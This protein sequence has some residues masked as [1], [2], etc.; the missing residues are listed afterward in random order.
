MLQAIAGYDAK[1]ANSVEMPVGDL[2]A[3]QDGSTRVKIGVPRKFFYADLD[4]EVASAVEDA[5][6][7][8]RS[9]GNDLLEIEIYVPTDRIL[10][11]AE[12][13]AYHREFI[14][15]SPELYQP[16]TLRRIRTGEDIS[17]AQVEQAERELKQTR[18]EIGKVFERVDFLVTPTAPIPAPAISDLKSDPNALRPC[19]LVLLRN[20]RPANVW[21]LP[22]ISIPCG[23]TKAGLPIGLQI[24]GPHWREDRVLQLAYAYEQ[25][26]GWHK[27]SLRLAGLDC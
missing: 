5:L 18:S 3:I 13:Y 23:F 16:E 27:R 20:T 1:D 7:V 8:L 12:S 15:R 21:G 14:S 9:L 19:E 17:A 22:A 6:G 25:A 26:T 2:A 11:A 24:I 4:A 10:Q